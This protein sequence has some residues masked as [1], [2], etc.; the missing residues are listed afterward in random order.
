MGPIE[1]GLQ[2]FSDR[3][4]L[5]CDKDIVHHYLH[6]MCE[7]LDSMVLQKYVIKLNKNET[8]IML[9]SRTSR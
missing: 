9:I 4:E 6:C 3:T 2:E 8:R 1:F 7:D 5:N